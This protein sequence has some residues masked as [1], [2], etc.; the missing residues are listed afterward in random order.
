MTEL[1]KKREIA[2]IAIK[3]IEEK[4]VFIRE[5]MLEAQQIA[6]DY[7]QP[8]DRYDGFR[9]QQIRYKGQLS[10]QMEN[11]TAD[12]LNLKK[13]DLSI[14]HKKVN[15][16]SLVITSQQKVFISISLGKISLY[17]EDYFLIST[18]VPFYQA[19]QGKKVGDKVIFNN[20]TIEILDV[21]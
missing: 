16:G 2:D 6:N 4:I 17:G 21:S 10:Q 14:K 13:I 11:L 7:G 9:N 3:L 20:K 15:L 12:L 18:S 8:K 19:I 5:T 1:S